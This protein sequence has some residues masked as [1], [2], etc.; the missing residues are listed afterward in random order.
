MILEETTTKKSGGRNKDVTTYEG[1]KS[2][3]ED[4]GVDTEIKTPWWKK[5]VSAGIQALT[6][7]V[8]MIAAGIQKSK[9]VQNVDTTL[10]PSDV[11]F[12]KQKEFDSVGDSLKY[13]FTTFDGLKRLAVDIVT[14]PTTYLTL[15]TGAAMKIAL[16]GGKKIAIEKTGKELI[17][18]L[19]E[20]MVTKGIKRN[21]AI[22]RAKLS[23]AK[24]IEPGVKTIEQR[25]GLQMI[26]K[27]LEKTGK[28]ITAKEVKT[29]LEG[30]LKGI[31][32][33]SAVRF[34]GKQIAELPKLG[35][36][37]EGV[38]NVIKKSD[39]LKPI[40]EGI[41]QTG[42]AIGKL[43]KRDM[44]LIKEYIPIKQGF[45]DAFDASRGR[46][47]NDIK[48][49]FS[50]INADERVLIAN[51]IDGKTVA[52]LPSK[53]KPLAE[54]VNKIFTSIAKEEEKRG[55]LTNTIDD[56]VTHLYKNKDKA[57]TLIQAMRSGQPSSLLRFDKVRSFP[58]LQMAKDAGLEPVEDIAEILFVRQIASEKAKLTQDFFTGVFKEG[59]TQK[60]SKLQK[61][62]GVSK[63]VMDL[64]R[65]IIPARFKELLKTTKVPISGGKYLTKDIRDILPKELLG[66]ITSVNAIDSGIKIL[67][68][69][70]SKT[71]EIIRNIEANIKNLTGLQ[72]FS[73]ELKSRV[74]L[75]KQ[76]AKIEYRALQNT[77][78]TILKEYKDKLNNLVDNLTNLKNV[79]VDKLPETTG[80]VKIK[81]E[82]LDFKPMKEVV[83]QIKKTN[84]ELARKALE[85]GDNFVRLSDSA[86]GMPQ[87]FKDIYVPQNIANDIAKLGKKFF[88]NEDAMKLVKGYDW[89][90]NKWKGSVTVWFPSFHFRNG[91]SN[92]M[93]NFLDIGVNAINPQTHK[94]VLDL[95]TGVD[96]KLITELGEEYTYA[97]IRKM[98]KRYGIFQDNL[99][100]TDVGRMLETNVFKKGLPM[101]ELGRKAGR[102]IE[103]EARM[104]DFITNIRRGF[105]FNDAADRVK[106][107]LFDYD[108]LSI[109]EK[110][111]MRRA[112]PFYTWTRKNIGL[113]FKTLLTQPGKQVSIAKAMGSLNDM[114]GMELSD[115]EKQYVPEWIQQGLN[116]LLQKQGDSTT[117]LTGFDLP[118]EQ[119]F[120]QVAGF[121]NTDKPFRS[122]L[123]Q[124]SPFIKAPLELATGI[125]FFA[126]K[127]ITDDD[128]GNFAERYPDVLKNWLE[129]SSK[130]VKAKTGNFT[131]MKVD[132][133]KKWFLKNITSM[134]GIGRLTSSGV[135]NGITSLYDLA[136]KG[137]IDLQDKANILRLFTAFNIQTTSLG[138][139]QRIFEKEQSEKIESELERKGDIG[140][141]E[142]RF[143]P[144]KGR[145]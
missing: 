63:D 49:I 71:R 31:E 8:R 56:Y 101:T 65:K 112:I 131:I 125:N 113:Q 121:A 74:L 98:A 75:G 68:E 47:A 127:D 122:I 93:Q 105:D 67:K 55:L 123:N 143:I 136:S 114:F 9:G 80:Y 102:A 85:T 116:I 16:Q 1:L 52:Q 34:A 61:T 99:A 22:S 104:V 128:S 142:R 115:D 94:T 103:N 37:Y 132:P 126:D 110:D 36:V 39:A 20:E 45:I 66:D 41:E 25:G 118:L 95:L 137:K 100:R 18:E 57:K 33:K 21:V 109:F 19:A 11:I 35:K 27:G 107:F 23:V 46:V 5:G 145:Q 50:G 83:R 140:V 70:V 119:F 73:K 72:N 24:L 59:G 139:G 87:A 7:S 90:N 38:S 77:Q 43:F 58:S 108:N 89:L 134:I 6:Y 51:A 138:T 4:K 117:F 17:K 135:I 88:D 92:T 48:T 42:E 3:A 13:Q 78:I 130:D 76:D 81:T 12:G 106:Q 60:L 14:D 129:F 82:V 111:V 26:K 91:I 40:M 84:P 28:E 97:E 30:G 144:K 141:M 62:L 44:G 32:R 86:T 10:M 120:E 15:G 124:L 53:L 79:N 96:G 64:K 54:R 69:Q 29:V 2:Y 133:K